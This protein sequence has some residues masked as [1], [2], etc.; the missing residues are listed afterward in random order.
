MTT[1]KQ[2]TKSRSKRQNRYS[3]DFKLR[4]V[5]LYLEEGYS[6]DMVSEELGIGRSTIS[7]WAKRYRE[8]GEAGLAYHM[9][10]VN[11][12]RRIS[13]AVKAKAVELKKEDPVRGSR[14]ISHLLERFHLMKASPETVRRT[15]K[16]EGLVEKPKQKPKRNPRPRR[17]H[18]VCEQ[19]LLGWN[20]RGNTLH[21]ILR[22]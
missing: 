5:K 14:R 22:L 21:G 3:V 11:A 13:P 16:E 8:E 9:P 17:K 2:S 10:A 7:A 12:P 19:G 1:K 6:A 18:G 4:A 15:L 20:P